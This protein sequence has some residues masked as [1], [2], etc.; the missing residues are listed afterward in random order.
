[1]TI[2]DRG[3]L[4]PRIDGFAFQRQYAEC[5]F[6]DSAKRFVANEALQGLDS[7]HEFTERERTFATEPSDTQAREILVRVVVGAI[8]NPQIFSAAAFYAGCTSPFLSRTVKSSGLTTMPSPPRAVSASHHSI[9][10]RSDSGTVRSTTLKSVASNTPGS[11][12]EPR[13]C[14][15]VPH[16]VLMRVDRSFRGHEVERSEFQIVDRSDGPAILAIRGDELR[17][18]FFFGREPLGN[19]RK[20]LAV[21][22]A[23]PSR[24]KRELLD[25]RAERDISGRADC[26]VL[27]AKQC[28]GLGRSGHQLA[29]EA[30]PSG[31][32]LGPKSGGRERARNRS[33]SCDWNCSS[34]KNFRP[35][36]V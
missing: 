16:V 17:D 31:V 32:E 8:D 23:E 20:Q 12:A 9:A 34:L 28:L 27:R 5:A 33:R 14:L 13:Q 30:G 10:A 4:K 18:G 26:R 7:Q 25:R 1:M 6:V 35:V 19:H 2:A 36:R 22:S 11:C 21:V 29:I 15:H 3:K 24:G